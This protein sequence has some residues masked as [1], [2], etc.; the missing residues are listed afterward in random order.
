MIVVVV[1]DVLYSKNVL[2]NGRQ[3]SRRSYLSNFTTFCCPVVFILLAN[4]FNE[5]LFDRLCMTCLKRLCDV[6]LNV[7][8]MNFFGFGATATF[9][10]LRN[11]I[12]Y[13]SHPSKCSKL[14]E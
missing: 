6:L 7:V 8:R 11:G 5:L 14:Y 2:K 3:C 9:P 10:I 13:E 4:V 1:V 12:S